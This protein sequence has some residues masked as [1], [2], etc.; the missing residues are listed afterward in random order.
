MGVDKIHL[1]FVFNSINYYT[2]FFDQSVAPIITTG[3]PVLKNIV[4]ASKYLLIF[5]R[6]YMCSFVEHKLARSA[7]Y[8]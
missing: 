3:D 6:L 8:C 4:Q 1:R 7:V 5:F 2:A